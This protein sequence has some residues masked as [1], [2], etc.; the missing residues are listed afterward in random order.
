MLSLIDQIKRANSA[1]KSRKE[2]SA[3]RQIAW[4]RTTEKAR[5]EH[6]A[7]AIERYRLVMI[8]HEWL[9]Q[10]KIE[11]MLGYASTVSTTFLKKLVELGHLERR[12]RD[13]AV[14]YNRIRGWEYRWKRENEDGHEL[15]KDC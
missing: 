1:I 13:N 7:K 12:N 6:T 3:E 2:Q 14:K 11:Q 5:R 8:T 15:P 9:T 4:Q 10:S